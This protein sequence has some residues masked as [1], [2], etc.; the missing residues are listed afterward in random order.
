MSLSKEANVIADVEHG[1]I[2][3]TVEIAA[4]PER[5][6]EALTR[7]EDVLRW[8]GAEGSY[9]TTLWEADVRPG[10]KWRAGG[11]S[12]DGRPYA[13]EGEFTEVDAPRK[14]VF[15]WRAGWDAPNETRVTYMLEPL[16]QGTRLTL[17][18]EGFAGR[19]PACNAHTSGWQ[20]VL[21]WLQ[22]DLRPAPAPVHY[23]L[24]KLHAPRPSFMLDM[25]A[26]ERALMQSHVAYWTGK[27]AEGKILA[28]GPVADPAGGWGMGL[29]R[30]SGAE[31]VDGLT[32]NDP[33]MLAAG[34]FR[35]EVLPMPRLVH[36]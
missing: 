1:I 36:V 19:V 13:V 27:M 10:G 30:V 7:D 4:T 18:H 16:D 8:W 6:F 20:R 15:T 11:R 2:L 23:F 28:F 21:G 3:A 24:F 32:A 33:V 17:H 35:Y 31:E 9:R 34:G 22:A 29:M 12:A 14:L 26:E 5:V 25:T